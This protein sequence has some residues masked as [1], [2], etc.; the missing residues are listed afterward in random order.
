MKP[1]YADQLVQPDHP[2]HST[3]MTTGQG[4]I[5]LSGR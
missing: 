4:I 3:P 2:G 1:G 5:A